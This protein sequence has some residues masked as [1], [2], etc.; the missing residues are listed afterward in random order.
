[1]VDRH[2]YSEEQDLITDPAERALAEARN[3]LR[4][5][6]VGML[7][8][9]RWLDRGGPPN[10]RPSDLLILNRFALESINRFA[11][12]FRTAD[13]KISGSSHQPP[14]PEAVP[15]LVEDF[16]DYVNQ[17]WA[18]KSAIHLAS[19]ALW[20]VNWIH[21]FVDGNGRTARIVSYMLLC[22]RLGYK[23]PGAQ[24]IPEQIAANKR[25]YY[26]ALE[27]ADLKFDGGRIDL[28]AIED[29]L[30]ECLARQLLTIHE[31]AA[32]ETAQPSAE[33]N[34]G[35]SQQLL[36]ADAEK[37]EI[38]V[39]PVVMRTV[40]MRDTGPRHLFALIESNPVLFTGIFSICA[41]IIGAIIAILFVR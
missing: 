30:K 31:K 8:L 38:A 24:T 10:L 4:Q 17:N 20:R 32:G 33:S 14:P 26:E 23:V 40:A 37:F 16:C 1:M 7:M 11:G 15:A 39:L 25:P 9:G 13:I 28:A 41:A 27:R 29:L 2:S 5:Y 12:T 35:R 19:Y 3:A 18:A 21:P 6:D 34:A 22:A 36:P